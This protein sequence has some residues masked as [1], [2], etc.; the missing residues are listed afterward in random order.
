MLNHKAL[1]KLATGKDLV[2][3][4]PD[5]TIREAEKW[6]EL[7]RLAGRSIDQSGN[8]VWSYEPKSRNR[9]I[10]GGSV[11]RLLIHNQHVWLCDVATKEFDQHYGGSHSM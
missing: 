4:H 6:L 10:K 11:W 9:S 8:L 7:W 1:Y 3:G 2:D 5:V